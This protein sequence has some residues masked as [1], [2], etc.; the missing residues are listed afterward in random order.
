ML[1]LGCEGKR[2]LQISRKSSTS[3]HLHTMFVRKPMNDYWY[4]AQLSTI[5][6]SQ[7]TARARMGRRED[8][9][10]KPFV[11]HDNKWKWIL[12]P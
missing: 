9:R 10:N 4:V 1:C 12:E 3:C 5:V 6:A 7:V 2:S 11:W 8:I